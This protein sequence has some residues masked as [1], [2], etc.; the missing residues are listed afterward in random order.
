MLPHGHKICLAGT[1]HAHRTLGKILHS[2]SDL[3]DPTSHGINT[4]PRHCRPFYSLASGNS[5]Q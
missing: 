2:S 5:S 3:Q 1:T 4:S